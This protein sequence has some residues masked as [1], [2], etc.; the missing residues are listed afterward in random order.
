MLGILIAKPNQN[1]ATLHS[2][3]IADTI[4]AGNDYSSA[5][6]RYS[7]LN[8]AELY[9]YPNF[10]WFHGDENKFSHFF[11]HVHINVALLSFEHMKRE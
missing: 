10:F 5:G 9:Q 7:K 4:Q 6:H 2:P 1:H 8:N 11:V 3:S